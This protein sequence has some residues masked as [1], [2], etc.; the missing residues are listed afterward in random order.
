MKTIEVVSPLSD[1]APSFAP[2]N[3][4]IVKKMPYQRSD[5]ADSSSFAD[6]N[7]AAKARASSTTLTNPMNLTVSQ[8]ITLMIFSNLPRYKFVFH[9]IR[10]RQVRATKVRANVNR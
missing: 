4:A 7:I 1:H 2:K 6:K 10:N 8:V 9:T 3:T 5:N